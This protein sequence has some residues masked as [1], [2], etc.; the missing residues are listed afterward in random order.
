LLVFIG[1]NITAQVLT[2]NDIIGTWN[3]VKVNVLEEMSD[4]D[5]LTMS[6][7]EAAFLKSAFIFKEDEN[8]SFDFEFE[9]MKLTNAHWKY[10]SQTESFDVQDWKDKD[11]SKRVL[12]GIKA[13]R[14]GEKV[15]FFLPETFLVLEV[16][17]IE[18][19][20]PPSS[21]EWKSISLGKLKFD[22]PSNWDIDTSGTMGAS[23]F[24]FSKVSDE[25]DQFRENINLI[26]QDISAYNLTLDQY[27]ELSK[28][29]IKTM[30]TEGNIILSERKKVENREFQKMVYTGKQGVFDLK[31]EQYYWIVDNEAY[32]LT[33]TCEL[34][35]FDNYQLIGEKILDSF[36]MK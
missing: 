14:Q 26:I 25:S 11:T 16:E 31:F 23:M 4:E 3:V 2:S 12:M 33:F 24:L 9:E 1:F 35:E 17:K 15:L 19:N 7:L 13:E 32:V 34:D 28:N 21:I 27:V 30:I 10:N 18:E 20:Q 29:Q 36:K 22:Y 8:F 6:M 5:K